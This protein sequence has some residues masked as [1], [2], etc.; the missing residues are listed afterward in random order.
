LIIYYYTECYKEKQIFYEIHPV[1]KMEMKNAA[2]SVI[3][4]NITIYFI[5]Y[6]TDNGIRVYNTRKRRYADGTTVFRGEPPTAA[7]DGALGR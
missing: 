5:K 3:F 2:N 1:R 6:W 7:A 4:C